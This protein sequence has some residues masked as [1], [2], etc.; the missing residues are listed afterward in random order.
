MNAL[1]L[2]KHNNIGTSCPSCISS[3]S[4]MGSD[5]SC[6]G[7]MGSIVRMAPKQTKMVTSLPVKSSV[8]NRSGNL[9]GMGHRGP[10]MFMKRRGMRGMGED[11]PTGYYRLK[12]F[13]VDTG[14]CLPNSSTAVEAAQSAL[15][16]SVGTGVATSP[17]NIAAAK[18]AGIKASLE[19]GA[20]FIADHPIAIASVVGGIAIL[21]LYGSGKLA[22][23][24]S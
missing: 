3:M 13:G 9:R 16:S 24:R 12:V 14:Q 18:Q 10:Q 4:G 11:C 22:F 23:G 2:C 21:A 17:S 1:G 8:L 20:K 6:S 19:K 15:V 7:E 5:C